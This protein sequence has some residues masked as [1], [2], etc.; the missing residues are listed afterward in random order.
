MASVE[1]IE[2]AAVSVFRQQFAEPDGRDASAARSFADFFH[3]LGFLF[4]YKPYGV[5]I[6]SPFGYSIFDLYPG[7][8]FSFQLHSEPKYEAFHILR[9]RPGS[10]VYL[11]SSPEWVE[12]GEKAALTWSE[13]GREFVSEYRHDPE[14][15]DVARITSTEVVHT[16][17][18]CTLEE[19]ATTSFDAVVRLLDQNDRSSLDL[20]ARHPD[21]G[22]LVRTLHPELPVQFVDRSESGWIRSEM[23]GSEPVIDVPDQLLGRRLRI[24]E[25]ARLRVPA[26]LG[27]VKVVVPT[28]SAIRCR[29]AGQEWAVSP[30]EL[31]VVPPAWEAEV[32][33]DSSTAVALHA[34]HPDLILREWAC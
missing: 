32:T 31:F 8:G 22:E 9:S 30:G 24:S 10:F 5:K 1:A 29:L 6:A 26:P 7:R 20:P 18:G 23:P 12:S 27:W 3:A 15:G 14:P 28:A 13:D 34:I 11:S 4:K 17:I 21:V 33:A 16:V 19:Y 25:G 2:R